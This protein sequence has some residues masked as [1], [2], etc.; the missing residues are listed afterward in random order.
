MQFL[1]AHNN[2][3]SNKIGKII[4]FIEQKIDDDFKNENGLFLSVQ[5]P[6]DE[7]KI[8]LIFNSEKI[9]DLNLVK[10]LEEEILI[11]GLQI[12]KKNSFQE[13][14]IIEELYTNNNL[15]KVQKSAHKL[16]GSAISV[17]LKSFAD[18]AFKIENNIKKN[19]P[20]NDLISELK[21]N[22]KEVLNFLKK[23]YEI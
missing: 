11:K 7:D 12:F 3:I 9:L 22:Y 19:K 13:I 2:L 21:E 17:G 23:K 4:L 10:D 14:K 16:G 20:V 6:L 5:K 18:I 15:I 8:N 1:K